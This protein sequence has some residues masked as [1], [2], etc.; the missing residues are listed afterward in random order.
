VLQRYFHRIRP[1]S[2]FVIDP[3]RIGTS[4]D[5]QRI[6][7]E[8]NSKLDLSVASMISRCAVNIK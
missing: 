5:Q 2:G 4:T 1:V 8:R 6:V 7:S 3:A